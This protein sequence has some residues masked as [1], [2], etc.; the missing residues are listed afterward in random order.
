[1]A[2][3]N[4]FDALRDLF[5]HV[6]IPP[7]I[8]QEVVIGGAGYPVSSLVTSAKGNWIHVRSL[9][10]VTLVE[11]L[12]EAGLHAGESEALVLAQENGAEVV[13]M[14]DQD[15]IRTPIAAD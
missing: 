3:L 15:G 13:L 5:G 7:A 1:M 14:D 11:S 6:V 2:A 4:D 12:I 10:D 9:Q 8:F